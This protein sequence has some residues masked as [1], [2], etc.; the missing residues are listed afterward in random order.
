MMSS[1]AQPRAMSVQSSVRVQQSCLLKSFVAS[2]RCTF[3][4]Q[5]PLRRQSIVRAEQK[6][7]GKDSKADKEV[8][9]LVKGKKRQLSIMNQ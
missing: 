9:K 7:N 1:V 2:S 4:R 6:E 3:R 8:S 5:A